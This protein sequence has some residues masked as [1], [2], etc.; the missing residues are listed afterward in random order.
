MFSGSR[1]FDQSGTCSMKIRVWVLMEK[2]Q[3]HQH[4][5]RIIN[6]SETAEVPSFSWKSTS[7]SMAK[8]NPVHRAWI[9]SG[10]TTQSPKN[11]WTLQLKGEWTCSYYSIAG[12]LLGPQNSD[13]WGVRILREPKIVIIYTPHIFFKFIGLP[14]CCAGGKHVPLWVELI[15]GGLFHPVSPWGTD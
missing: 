7:I 15:M 2:H 9:T 12:V 4:H 11:H 10:K 1:Q 14:P 3:H 8:K 5:N 13:F 6:E